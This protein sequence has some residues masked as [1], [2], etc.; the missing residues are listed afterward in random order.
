MGLTD[1]IWAFL[2]PASFNEGPCSESNKYDASWYLWGWVSAWLRWKLVSQNLLPVWFQVKVVQRGI[3]MRKGSNSCNLNGH[4]SW[5]GIPGG[6]GGFQ[7]VLSPVLCILICFLTSGPSPDAWLW[8]PK[9]NIF[10]HSSFLVVRDGMFSASRIDWNLSPPIPSPPF[11][12]F[13]PQHLS[14]W[15]TVYFL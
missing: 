15:C 11:R 6:A 4:H 9:D 2:C 7:L 10:S 3:C 8:S 13:S 1:Y 12:F 14:L 5:T